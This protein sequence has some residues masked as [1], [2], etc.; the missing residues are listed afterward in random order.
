MSKGE[1]AVFVVPANEMRNP[2]TAAASSSN[3][4]LIPDPPAKA[5]QVELCVHL[6]DLV[7]V[8]WQ[9]QNLSCFA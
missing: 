6:Q 5:Q 3:Q 2:A 4:Q 7:Q 8:C 1:T 9:Q